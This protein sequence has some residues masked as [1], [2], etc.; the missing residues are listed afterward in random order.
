VGMR[1]GSAVAATSA[2]V[3]LLRAV[4]TIFVVSDT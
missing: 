1:E 2:E 3:R 4:R